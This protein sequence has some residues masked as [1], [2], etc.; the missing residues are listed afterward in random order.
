MSK[1]HYDL[2][3]YLRMVA[4]GIYGAQGDLIVYK[5][6][7]CGGERARK[8]SI[9]EMPPLFMLFIY[10]YWKCNFPITRS[11]CTVSRS[12]GWSVCWFVDLSYFPKRAGS[13]ISM[14][15]LT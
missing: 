8:G 11:F 10:P 5:T 13:L 4:T 7:K 3:N 6:S 14:M 12:V 9:I 2:W 1:R 15:L